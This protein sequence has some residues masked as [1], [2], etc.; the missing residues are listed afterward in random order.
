MAAT[1]GHWPHLKYEAVEFAATVMSGTGWCLGYWF[2]IIALP[3]V[4]ESVAL[5]P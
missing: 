2:I 3:S 1:T 4:T 5:S